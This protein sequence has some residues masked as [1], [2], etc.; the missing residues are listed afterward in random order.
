MRIL[1]WIPS[2]ITNTFFFSFVR[3]PVRS[4]SIG[5]RSAATRASFFTITLRGSESSKIIFSACASPSSAS[6]YF[7]K[8]S[9]SASAAIISSIVFCGGG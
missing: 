3:S 6:L 2:L 1:Y 5:S 8:L 4:S 7:R 9:S